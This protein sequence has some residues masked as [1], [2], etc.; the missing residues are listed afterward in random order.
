M[1]LNIKIEILE[2]ELKKKLLVREKRKEYNE[3]KQNYLNNMY[4]T[5]LNSMYGY[6]DYEDELTSHRTR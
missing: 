6:N 4:R 1:L 2:Y 5:Y 3:M